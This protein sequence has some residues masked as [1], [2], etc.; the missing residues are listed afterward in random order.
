MVSDSP[1]RHALYY[2]RGDHGLPVVRLVQD[3]EAQLLIELGLRHGCSAVQHGDGVSDAGDERTS[4]VE[5]E[6]LVG[7]VHVPELL[8]GSESLALDLAHL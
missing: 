1:L 7:L 8:L 3:L 5:R 2:M 4:L 6:L